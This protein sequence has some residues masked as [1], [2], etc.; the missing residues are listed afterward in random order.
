M[1]VAQ[2]GLWAPALLCTPTTLAW[3]E[4]A[5]KRGRGGKSEMEKEI[6]PPQPPSLLPTPQF[7]SLNFAPSSPTPFDASQARYNI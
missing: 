2:S 5:G 6:L 4:G 7:L 1:E 3:A